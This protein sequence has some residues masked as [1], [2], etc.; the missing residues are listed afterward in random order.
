MTRPF[1]FGVQAFSTESA[2]EWKGLA[3]GAEDL[4]YSCFHL[5]DHYIGPGAA[6]N[7]SS[8]PPQNLAALPAMAVAAAVTESI[9]I[10]ARVMCVD[11]HQPVVLAQSLATM[12][13]ALPTKPMP[14]PR[15]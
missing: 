12:R 7:A 11:Y 6:M 10:G 1:R 5:A 2:S 3:R 4:G 8:H 9:L 13:S 15:Q 14:P